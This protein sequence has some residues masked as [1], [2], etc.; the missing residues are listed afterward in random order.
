MS[1]KKLSDGSERC[2]AVSCRDPAGRSWAFPITT[3][4][5]NRIEAANADTISGATVTDDGLTDLDDGDSATWKAIDFGV[6][7]G[8]VRRFVAT[9]AGARTGGRIE[10]WIDGARR[11]GSL[12]LKKSGADPK[13][14]E[15]TLGAA[16]VSGAHDVTL[17]FLGGKRLG[18]L[19]AIEFR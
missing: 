17:K 11:L 2:A 18:T 12:A 14:Q 16:G 7:A 10:V 8:G 5:R 19:T 1:C 6:A 4:L 3:Y 15:T 9:V 13:P